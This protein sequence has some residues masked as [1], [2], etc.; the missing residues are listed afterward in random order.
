MLSSLI[1][2]MYVSLNTFSVPPGEIR[3]LKKCDSRNFSI[4]FKL[5]N[6]LA[7]FGRVYNDA[8]LSFLVL[9]IH[10]FFFSWCSELKVYQSS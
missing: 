5:S 10:V 2:S 6:L 8:S 4:S 7:N 9:A 1:S 3:L